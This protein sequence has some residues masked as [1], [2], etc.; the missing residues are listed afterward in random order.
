MVVVVVVEV[1][2]DRHWRDDVIIVQGFMEVQQSSL[3]RNV[4]NQ[5]EIVWIT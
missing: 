4:L 5:S 2:Y 1:N 3:I